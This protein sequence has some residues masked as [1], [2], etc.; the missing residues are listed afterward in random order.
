MILR[1]KQLISFVLSKKRWVIERTFGWL[2]GYRRLFTDY[3]L[4]P[5]HR[6]RLST[7]LP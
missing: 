3:G 1:S 6:R 5:E 7:L 4:Y 2:I